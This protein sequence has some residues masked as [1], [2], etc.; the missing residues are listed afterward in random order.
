MKQVLQ[1]LNTGKTE[2][3]EI[4][5][6]TPSSGTALVRNAASLVSAGTE[7]ALV[8][9]A[10]KSLLGKARSRPDLLRQ[11]LDKARREGLLNA[12]RASVGRLDEAMPLGYS[13]AGTIVELG[14]GVQGFRVGQRVACA[15]G[16]YAVHAEYIVVPQNLLAAIPEGVELESAAFATLGAIAMHGFRLAETQIGA[17]VAVIGLGLLGQ[18][19]ASIAQSAGCLVLGIDLDDGRVAL[20]RKRALKAIERKS[21]EETAWSMTHGQ[22]FD[23]VL[24]CAD[25]ESSDPVELAGEIARDRAR[26]V[27]IG[28]VGMQVPRRTYYAKELNLIVSR[29]YGPG[30]YDPGYEEAGLDY[31]IG[32]VRWTEGRNLQAFV[33]L[34]GRG[35]IDVSKLI[36]HRFP[37]EKATRAYDLFQGKQAFLGVLITYPKTREKLEATKRLQ[38][39]SA[40]RPLTKGRVRLGV[41]GAGNFAR[42]TMLPALKGLRG[43]ELV[44]IASASGRQA[45]DLGR[46]YGFRYASSDDQQILKDK[47]IDAVA[48][49]TRHHLHGSQTLAALK[50]SK[51]VFC[52]KPLALSGKELSAIEKTITKQGT[53][54]LMVGFNRRFAPLVKQLVSFIGQ[55]EQPLAAHYRVNAGPLPANHW[56]LDPA[57]GGGRLLGEGC[58]FIDFLTFLAGTPPVSVFTQALSAEVERG[59]ENLQVT[60]RFGDGSL[61][62]LTYL[63]NGDRS[64]PK[65]RLEVFCGG[66]VAI[67]DDFRALDLTHNGHTRGLRGSQDKGHRAAWQAFISSLRTGAPPPIPYEQ[68]IGGLRATFA[69]L[70]S[71]ETGK[72][73][74]I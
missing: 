67:L 7:R 71:L 6:P 63:S 64:L 51:H 37:I 26:V 59:Q 3:I 32:Y 17:R 20:A 1:K 56:L 58:H 38:F 21:A 25:A 36:S 70:R 48:V 2:V 9:F 24:V 46:R 68:L 41:L 66:K 69:A 30:R 73:V 5:V 16:G 14:R 50:A 52:E 34:L 60:L 15:G 53:G 12:A 54:L 62:T 40:T 49:L 61:G 18:L 72:E 10:G 27:A 35:A 74:E 31:P 39:P 28:A 4:P 42:Y 43:I 8:E 47:A 23:A 19:A 11:V 55:R 57:Q 65:E 45:A 13:S 44:G 33:D 29:S 22:G